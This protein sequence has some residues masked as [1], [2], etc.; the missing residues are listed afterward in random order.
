MNGRDTHTGLVD[1]GRGRSHAGR[2]GAVEA[3]FTILAL[4][5]GLL[6]PTL[7]HVAPAPDFG[8]ELIPNEPRREQVEFAASTS[9]GFGGH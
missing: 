5:R 2:G 1:E 9:F 6:P 7:H 3:I 4:H 8:L